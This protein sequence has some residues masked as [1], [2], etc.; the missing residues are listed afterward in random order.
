MG[1]AVVDVNMRGTGC[2]G[3]AFDYFEPLEQLDAYDVIETVAHQ[4]WVL[5]HKVGHVRHLLRRHQP[6]VRRPRAPAGPR[7]DRAAVG[8]RRDRDD[9]LPRRRPEHRL[10]GGV[11][12]RAPA[13]RRTGRPQPTASTGPTNRSRKATRPV[14]PTRTCTE[15]QRTCS[16]KSKK[17]RP[18][19]RLWP[20]R[21][22]RSRSCTT[23]RSRPS[24]HASGRTSRPADTAPTW[25]S[26]SPA[27]RRSGSRSPT[28]SIPTRWIR[29]PSIGCMTSWSCSSRTKRR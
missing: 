8:G 2:S 12:R 27:R 29:L 13:Q 24:W 19:T 6:A 4:S 18:T 23:S 10:R 22:I 15:R 5:K 14:R 9:P 21:W 25:R 3:G 26:T 11:G 28:A 16:E 1:F 17:T 20:T 7:G